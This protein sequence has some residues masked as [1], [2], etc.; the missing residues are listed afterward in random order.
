MIKLSE[1][2]EEKEKK[3]EKIKAQISAKDK[4]TL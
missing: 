4:E 2:K 3:D 1:K